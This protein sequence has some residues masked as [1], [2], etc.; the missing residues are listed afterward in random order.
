MPVSTKQQDTELEKENSKSTMEHHG[1]NSSV[2]N[3]RVTIKN[4]AKSNVFTLLEPVSEEMNKYIHIQ[5]VRTFRATHP[6]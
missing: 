6:M 3:D 5:H 2:N 1:K 4:H